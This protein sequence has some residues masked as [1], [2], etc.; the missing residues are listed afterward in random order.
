VGE[1]ERK[2]A[3]VEGV[4]LLKKVQDGVATEADRGRMVR[5]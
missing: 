2:V 5:A 4:V 3:L 1:E